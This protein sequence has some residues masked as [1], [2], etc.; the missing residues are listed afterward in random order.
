MTTVGY[1]DFFAQSMP[2]MAVTLMIIFWGIFLVSMMVVTL[3]NSISLDAKE[4]R[5]YNIL[6]RLKTREVLKNKA[7]QILVA[8]LR[9]VGM[10]KDYE[11]KRA[12][13]KFNKT[14]LKDIF[15]E[16]DEQRGEARSMLE[17]YKMQ[18]FDIKKT[19]KPNSP[20]PAEE[21]RKMVNIIN[22]DF[23]D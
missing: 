5:A 21:L 8:I 17:I 16:Y 13:P 6:F 12:N 2:G 4:S 9:I 20:D 14:E 10:D 23:N 7:A 15:R 11:R 1:G 3:T 19:L 22:D 18:F